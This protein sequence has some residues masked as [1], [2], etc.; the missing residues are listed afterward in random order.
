MA[1]EF[2][3]E[4]EN[5]LL[6]DELRLH[7]GKIIAEN[8]QSY[9]DLWPGL[10]NNRIRKAYSLYMQT[11]KLA[12]KNNLNLQV[13]TAPR[14]IRKSRHHEKKQKPTKLKDQIA[15]IIQNEVQAASKRIASSVANLI[16]DVI[17]EN[18]TFKE[19][20]HHLRPY[21]ELVEKNYKK[22]LEFRQGG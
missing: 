8:F 13:I 3:S 7:D 20:L 10:F 15:Y 19:E 14:R 11:I 21:K 16:A 18:T 6:L 9:E 1:N 17:Q 22:E 12:T 5:K 2:Y 4:E